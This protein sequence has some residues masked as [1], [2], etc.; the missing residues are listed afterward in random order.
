M[1][2]AAHPT[3]SANTLAE[4]VA[5]AKAHPGRLSIGTA[6]NGSPPDLVARLLARTAGIDVAFIPFRTGAEGLTGVMRG[7][8]S[9]F[10]DAPPMIAP[11]AKAGTVKVL[12]VTGRAREPELPNAQT[13][14]EAGFPGVEREAW[15]GLV[16]PAQTPTEI[17]A[18]LGHEIAAILVAPEV[19]QRLAVLGFRPLIAT[20]DEFRTLIL[21][22]HKRWS[23]IIR[24]AGIKLD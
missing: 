14:A 20:R 7:D 22:E 3:V 15:I 8:V 9:L 10:V 2:V 4:F 5:L 17:S 11:Q 24:E 19:Q 16:A 18:R 13:V 6:G 21:D 23:T 12:A 1:A